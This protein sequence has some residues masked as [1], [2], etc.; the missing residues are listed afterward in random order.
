MNRVLLLADLSNL[1]F[2]I[3]KKYPSQKLD[4]F[5]L[6]QHAR[7]HNQIYRALAYGA[8]NDAEANKFFECLRN[9]GFYV[10]TEKPKE[11]EN[12]INW[13]VRITVDAVRILKRIDTLVISSSDADLAP[14]LLY[15]REYGVRTMVMACGISKELKDVADE[16]HEIGP[17][18]LTG[19]ENETPKTT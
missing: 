2:C 11:N 12:K 8:Q 13:N 19:G 18:L 7:G 5:K 1:Y 16:H 9:F 4:Y 14:L 6:L 17:S 10:F 15:A 3:K